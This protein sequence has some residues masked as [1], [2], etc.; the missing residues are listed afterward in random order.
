MKKFISFT[1][2]FLM[3]LSLSINVFAEENSQN[4][5]DH[6][7]HNHGSIILLEN[8]EIIEN[9]EDLRVMNPNIRAQFCCSPNTMRKTSVIL[10][11]CSQIGI[12]CYQTG[13]YATMC[14]YCNTIWSIDG[15]PFFYGTHIVR[16]SPQCTIGR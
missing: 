14:T 10:A 8:G 4:E 1:L 15:G 13:Y 3:M 5:H 6:D 16:T 11:Y 7:G 2:T 9:A 12:T